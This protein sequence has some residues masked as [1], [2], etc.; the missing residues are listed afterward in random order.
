MGLEQPATVAVVDGTTG[1]A[2]TFRSL[3]QLLGKHYKLL[4]RQRHQKQ[5]NAHQ[6]HKAQKQEA[7]NQFG[8][9][10]LGQ[11][12][13]RLLAKAIVTLAQT[14]QAASKEESILIFLFD[15]EK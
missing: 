7:N 10:E 6:R 2:V 11:Y 13:D 8:E 12:I 9:S 3:K 14:Y 4:N 5:Q 1:E 15:G